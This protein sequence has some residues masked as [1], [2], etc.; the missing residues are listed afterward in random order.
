MKHITFITSTLVRIV[1]V[2]SFLGGSVF[3]LINAFIINKQPVNW[4]DVLVVLGLLSIWAESR[5]ST[6]TIK[7]LENKLEDN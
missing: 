5:D 3:Y 4:F 1:I 7:E 2:L 6:A